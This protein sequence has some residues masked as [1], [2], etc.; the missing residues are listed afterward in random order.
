MTT[1]RLYLY[2]LTCYD[3]SW[4]YIG[5]T[6]DPKRRAQN[7]RQHYPNER[8]RVLMVGAENYVLMMERKLIQYCWDKGIPIR[9]RS[10]KNTPLHQAEMS[11]AQKAAW[12]QPDI[13]T[14]RIA[15]MK[16]AIERRGVHLTEEHRTNLS[17]AMRAAHQ[18]RK[19][20]SPR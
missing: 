10:A 16:C 5:A 7:W 6:I 18:R 19:G 11:R 3:R 4:S 12:S 15:A 17:A 8:L 2:A 9:N 1:E 20:N 13:K 14:G